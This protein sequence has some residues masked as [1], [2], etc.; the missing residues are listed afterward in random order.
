MSQLAVNTITNAA[1]GSTAQ[2][3]GM[4]PTADSLQGFRNRIINGD[5][6]I[7]Q[8]GT[9]AV[10][11]GGAFP[12]DR[13][14]ITNN[15][16][17]AYSGQQDTSAPAGFVNS[18]KFTTTTADASLSASQI[19]QI[20]HRIEGTNVADLGWG[21][22]SAKTVTLSFWVRS[23]LTGTFGG[24]VQNSA[25]N[26][27]YPFTYTISVADTWE[28][29]TITIAGDTSGTWLTTTGS[30]IQIRF[31]MGMGSDYEGTAGAWVGSDKRTA[32]GAVSVIGTLNATWYVTGVQLEVGSVATPFER[33][34]FGTELALCQRYCF[35][36]LNAQFSYGE[37][38]HFNFHPNMRAEPTVGVTTGSASVNRVR[39]QFVT[40]NS[41][42]GDIAFIANA[43]L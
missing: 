20:T 9:A 1:G 12:V 16:D 18:L 4:T 37:N 32:T 8:R 35:R 40:F 34:P 7:A 27:S 11:T 26:R 43:E 3:N 36:L 5:M 2:I 6:R 13:F 23:S 30:G 15:T 22:A 24:A 33:R 25:N 10:T 28:Y 19:N 29:K 42:T 17:G 41:F 14:F 39:Q 31:G 38:K 21:T